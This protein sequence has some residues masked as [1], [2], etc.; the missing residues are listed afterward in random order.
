MNPI[1]V[2][3]YL[4]TNKDYLFPNENYT[5]NEV[6]NALL[7]APHACG[8][9][10]NTISFKNPSTVKLISIFPGSLGVDRFYLGE[11]KKGILKYF[12]FGGLG[13]WWIADII[14]AKKRCC[15]YNC[16]KLMDFV[17]TFPKETV[18]TSE[19][20]FSEITSYNYADGACENAELDSKDISIANPQTESH[21][22][23]ID[24]E[25]AKVMAKT[26]ISVGKTL[27][28][29]FKSIQDTMYIK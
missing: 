12:T 15:Q 11:I 4:E 6:E 2:A 5:E 8:M 27:K 7:S 24:K 19:Q 18:I 17:S 22:T 14:S 1:D 20:D 13:I 28:D 9:R 21:K 26:A 29:G 23:T 25:K 3:R 10:L 16:K